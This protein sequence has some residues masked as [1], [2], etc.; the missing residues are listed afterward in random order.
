[1]AHKFLLLDSLKCTFKDV[2]GTTVRN[3]EVP[4]DQG[5]SLLLPQMLAAGFHAGCSAAAAVRLSG[6]EELECKITFMFKVICFKES[7]PIILPWIEFHSTH[8]LKKKGH[9]SKCRR[10]KKNV[11]DRTDSVLFASEIRITGRVFL[12]FHRTGS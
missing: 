11:D 3:L 12:C 2:S 8:V 4:F 6:R 7:S 5:L 9:Q 1:M 10:K